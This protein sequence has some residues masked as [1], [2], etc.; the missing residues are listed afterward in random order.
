MKK[1]MLFSAMI[2]LGLGLILSGCAQKT[3]PELQTPKKEA[4]AQ[5]AAK[6]GT[7]SQKQAK[8]GGGYDE[9]TVVKG[10]CLW[11]IAGL[12]S[13][14]GDPF[15]W[16]LIFDANKDKIKNPDLIYPDQV[17]SYPLNPATDDVKEARI[18]AGAAK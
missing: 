13:V 17:F 16:P 12:A 14:Y 1:W 5:P 2:F 4:G 10:E 18:R 6:S 15:Q 8:K 7:E 11:R 3:G 9:H